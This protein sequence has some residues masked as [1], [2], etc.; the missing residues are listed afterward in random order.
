MNL[1]VT[2]ESL[3]PGSIAVLFLVLTWLFF[4]SNFI[5]DY[6]SM[7][8]VVVTVDIK[9]LVGRLSGF[10]GLC[11]RISIPPL[12]F[13]VPRGVHHLIQEGYFVQFFF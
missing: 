6:I 2:G 8:H 5:L 10:S 12:A 11:L 7:V 1:A 9:S 4:A 13:L 3:V